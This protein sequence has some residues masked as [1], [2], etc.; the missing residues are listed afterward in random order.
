VTR[1]FNRH[2]S[3]EQIILASASPRRR[4]LLEKMGIDFEVITADVHELDAQSSPELTPLDLALENARRK[5][6]AVAQS[7]QAMGRW[8]LG[9]DTVVALESRVFGKPASLHQAG[10]YLRALSG[11]MH[12]VITGC[13]LLG[14]AGEKEFFHDVSR[15]TFHALSDDVIARYLAE[16]H[17]LDKA[18]A[19]ALQERGEW[20]IQDVAG[21]RANVIG[22]P[23]EVLEKVL[24]R[25]G[26][27]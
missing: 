11:R 1:F 14:P 18:G 23:V 4:E 2:V 19:Y 16:V 27:R 21:S 3:R 5:A 6:R 26:L 22:L 20:L 17:V 24:L 8:V 12:E 13:T 10:D 25:R 15:V 9:A 7:A